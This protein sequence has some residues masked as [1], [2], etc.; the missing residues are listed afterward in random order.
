VL[1]RGVDSAPLFYHGCKARRPIVQKLKHLFSNHCETHERHPDEQLKSRYYKTTHAT[2]VKTI[3]ELIEKLPG[4]QLLSVSEERGEISFSVHRGKKAFVVV[5][6]ISVRPFETAIDFSVTT[7]TKWLPIDFG[8]S[9][10]LVIELYQKLDERL[11][12]IGSGM[13]SG[14]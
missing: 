1:K 6:V 9:R 3:K 8:F 12:Y 10:N 7:E 11:P 14:T 13:Y 4:F 2:A 5:T